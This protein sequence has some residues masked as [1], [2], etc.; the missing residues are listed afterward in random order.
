MSTESF[1]EVVSGHFASQWVSQYPLVPISF[2]NVKFAQPTD[3][4]WVN[5]II[6]PGDRFA[7]AI[8]QNAG[9]RQM[10]V[11]NIAVMVPQDTGSKASNEMVDHIVSIFEDLKLTV[12]AFGRANFFNTE[13]RKRGNISGYYTQNVQIEFQYDQEKG[14]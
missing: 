2:E 12:T 9:R 13:V 7:T 1:R 6:V 4:A 5:F 10:G 3:T 14:N 8:G 11:L